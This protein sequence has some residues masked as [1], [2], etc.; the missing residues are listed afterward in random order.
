[1]NLCF[2]PVHI[3]EAITKYTNVG[4]FILCILTLVIRYG[5]SQVLLCTDMAARGLDIPNTTLVIQVLMYSYFCMAFPEVNYYA[6]S[7]WQIYVY[8]S[9]FHYK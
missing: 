6:L 8:F 5:D 3:V 7:L 4:T 1:M 9:H 2:V